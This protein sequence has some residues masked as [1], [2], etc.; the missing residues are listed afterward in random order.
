[1]AS[2]E[3][4]ITNTIGDKAVINLESGDMT[5]GAI[6]ASASLTLSDGSLSVAGLIGDNASITLNGQSV[7]F[8]ASAIGINSRITMDQ[9]DFTVSGLIGAGASLSLN[10]VNLTAASIGA[11][12]NISLTEGAMSIDSIGA[13]ANVALAQGTTLSVASGASSM[14]INNGSTSA[15]LLNIDKGFVYEIN[16][17]DGITSIKLNETGTNVTAWD[18]ATRINPTV[19][20]SGKV[21]IG[22]LAI[23]YVAKAG[24][25]ATAST[26]AFIVDSSVKL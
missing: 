12:A 7:A 22:G 19:S 10:E 23:D 4:N 25:S 14:M 21:S 20:E 9:G 15:A 5:V 3:L 11:G 24:A 8:S 16:H 17:D 13:N 1:M 6:G 18:H 26:A 2:G